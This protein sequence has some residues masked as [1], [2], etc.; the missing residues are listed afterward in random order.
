MTTTLTTALHWFMEANP[1][2]MPEHLQ[3]ETR[4]KS[5]R[6]RKPGRGSNSQ[7]ATTTASPK[8]TPP[9][10]TIPG[11]EFGPGGARDDG[12]TIVA[13]TELGA[14][15]AKARDPKSRKPQDLDKPLTPAAQAFLERGLALAAQEDEE[16]ARY[17][18][19]Q[20]AQRIAQQREGL[21]RSRLQQMQAA[22]PD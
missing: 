4:A 15:V 12:V 10:S 1:E 19:E 16:D 6:G 2:G 21:L 9:P 14:Y 20:K 17:F 11:S 8:V 18:A 22:K 3:D 13:E 5:K 7:S